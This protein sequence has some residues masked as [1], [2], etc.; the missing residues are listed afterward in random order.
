[1]KTTL[2]NMDLEPVE[3]EGK[4]FKLNVLDKSYVLLVHPWPTKEGWWLSEVST[5]R[6]FPGFHCT[7]EADAL[8][9]AKRH[10]GALLDR[11]GDAAFN[12]QMAPIAVLQQKA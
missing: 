9:E 2:L 1:M 8:D 11:I 12:K 7:V 4:P 5:G 3:V 10:V 6:G